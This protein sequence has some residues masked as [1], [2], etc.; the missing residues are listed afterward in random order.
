[1]NTQQRPAWMEG[2]HGYGAGAGAF[3]SWWKQS[4]QA[5]LPPRWRTLLGL[6]RD[7]LLLVPAGAQLQLRLQTGDALRDLALLPLPLRAQELEAVLGERL[8]GVPRWLL[9]APASALQRNLILPAAAAERLRDVVGFEIDRQTPFAADAVRFDARVLARRADGQLEVE[10]VAV[11]RARFDAAMAGLGEPAATLAGVEVADAQGVP[12]GVNLLPAAQR[13][14]RHDPR[15]RW[16]LALG[17]V[18]LLALA[19]LGWQILD[20]RRAAA[21]AFVAQV[22]KQAA[23][24]RQ[25]SAQR[26]QLVDIVEGLDYLDRLRAARPTTVEVLNEVSQRLPDDTYLEKFAIEGDRLLLIGFSAE[27]S[28]LV[29]KMEGSPLWRAPALSGPLQPD[30]RTRRDRF[31]MTAELVGNAAATPAPPAA[32]GAAR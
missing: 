15:K 30:P 1:M 12:L 27:A 13:S 2:L 14:R 28:A 19:A 21:E 8:A 16:N 22:E 32:S 29:A 26:Q 3:L 20:N 5:W 31:S 7:R 4:L 6:S 10:L 9:L 24:A 23:Q 17:A 18:A 11:P 25:V